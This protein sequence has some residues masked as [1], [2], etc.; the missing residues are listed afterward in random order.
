MLSK[1]D[2]IRAALSELTEGFGCVGSKSLANQLREAFGRH[3][4]RRLFWVP[5][6]DVGCVLFDDSRAHFRRSYIRSVDEQLRKLL[7]LE[8]VRLAALLFGE[9]LNPVDR[10]IYWLT[11][12]GPAKRDR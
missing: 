2:Q 10:L 7:Q 11:Q 5:G 4:G 1:P 6:A 8:V 12:V 3:A 9:L